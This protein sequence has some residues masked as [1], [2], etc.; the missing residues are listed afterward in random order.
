MTA[1]RVISEARTALAERLGTYLLSA[2]DAQPLSASDLR[3]YEEKRV[4]R[5][6]RIPDDPPLHL[7][8]DPEF[9]YSPPRI[10][11]PDETQRLLWPHVESAGILCVFPAQTTIDAFDPEGVAA[12]LI[13][14]ARDLIERNRSGNL[15][16]NPS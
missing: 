6:W 10:A 8:L 3:A 1:G 7:L 11:L 5:G 9:P 15:E 14:E 4:D 16:R 12:A 13:T 2:F